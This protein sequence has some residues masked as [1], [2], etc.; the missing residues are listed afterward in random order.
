MGKNNLTIKDIAKR[1]GFSVRTVSRVINNGQYVKEETRKIINDVIKETGFETNI[2]AKSLRKKTAKNIILVIEKQQDLYPGQWYSNMFQNI[3]NQASAY[4]YNVFMF[5]F[6]MDD[7]EEN[8]KNIHLLKS[9]F[10]DGAI[11]LNIQKDDNKI[12]LF[13]ELGIPYVTIGKN[14]NYPENPFVEIDNYKASYLVTE[15]LIRSGCKSILFFLG[16]NR[17]ISNEERREGFYTAVLDN[18]LQKQDFIIY[19]GIKSYKEAYTA[20]NKIIEEG[21]LPDAIFVSGDEKA[22]GVLKS[23]NEKGISIPEDIQVVGFDNIP[24]SEF[25]VPSLTTVEQNA[26]DISSKAIE[27]LIGM[28]NEEDNYDGETKI[29]FDPKIIYRHTTRKIEE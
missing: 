14:Y 4:E 10:V 25:T 27:I 26:K 23:L 20:C 28:I 12:R 8:K 9:G 2:Y 19:E 6:N 17:Y 3:I 11:I 5:Q 24:I 29:I 7:E 15:Y 22:F 18:K 1:T 21:Q 16:S 13:Q